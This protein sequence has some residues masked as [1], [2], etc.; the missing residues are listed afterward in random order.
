LPLISDRTIFFLDKG[1]IFLFAYC[2]SFPPMIPNR[3]HLLSALGTTVIVLIFFAITLSSASAQLNSEFQIRKI[4]P[5][6]ISTPT[7]NYVTGPV[8]PSRSKNWMELEVTFEWHPRSSVEKFADDVMVNYYVLMT[9]KS[10]DSP[11][12]T[13]LTGQVTLVSV[14][15]KTS[16]PRRTVMYLSH[17]TMQHFSGGKDHYSPQSVLNNI[18]VTISYHGKVVAEKS[19]N[20]SGEW[21]KNYQPVTGYLVSKEMSPFAP[22]FSD[23]YEDVKKP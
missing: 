22:L 1:A 20:G 6:I 11:N 14:P 13:L 18:G 9:E 16:T 12:G 4:S 5:S 8:K 10:V 15:A 7:L 17:R 21:W 23:Y 3:S 19:L 2:L